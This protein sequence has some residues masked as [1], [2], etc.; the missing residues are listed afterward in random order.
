MCLLLCDNIGFLLKGVFLIPIISINY[1]LILHNEHIYDSLED[2][3]RQC[4]KIEEY[5]NKTN[6][7]EKH[8]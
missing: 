4:K 2:H 1:I 3:K 7:K 5:I 8:E 6:I